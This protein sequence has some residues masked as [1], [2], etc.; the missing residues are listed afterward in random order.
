MPEISGN[1][2][3]TAIQAVDE[4]IH[5]LVAQLEHDNSPDAWQLVCCPA[6]NWH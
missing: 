6:N 5:R 3:A 4:K 2:L 1:T